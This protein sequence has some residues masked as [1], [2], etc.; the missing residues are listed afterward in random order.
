[1]QVAQRQ[2]KSN[3]ELQTGAGAQK[4]ES[5]LKCAGAKV[6]RNWFLCN[7]FW[8]EK[9]A[10]AEEK[11]RL[12]QAA[13]TSTK[14]RRDFLECISCALKLKFHPIVQT[15][16]AVFRDF[17]ADDNIFP[18][19]SPWETFSLRNCRLLIQFRAQKWK[20]ISRAKCSVLSWRFVTRGILE[21]RVVM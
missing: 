20:L 21:R 3:V 6:T 19:S 7:A 15:F 9:F 12:R 1:M 5:L 2:H 14:K 13:A 8:H 17:V 16:S 10:S 11:C 18:F 4:G